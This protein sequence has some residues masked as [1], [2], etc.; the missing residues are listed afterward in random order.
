MVKIYKLGIILFIV[1]GVIIF[2]SDIMAKKGRISSLKKLLIIKVS[3]LII[4]A[5][6]VILMIY[7]Q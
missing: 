6:S 1:S 7:G 4:A 5:L 3:A 2:G